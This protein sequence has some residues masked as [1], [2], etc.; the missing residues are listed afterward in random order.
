MLDT[1]D[2]IDMLDTGGISD[3]LD[4]GD[5]I[6]MLD[7]GGISDM[8]GTEGISDNWKGMQRELIGSESKVYWKERTCELVL[9]LQ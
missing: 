8:L 3:M 1:G 2:I 4:T 7:T 5:I 9:L 6:D